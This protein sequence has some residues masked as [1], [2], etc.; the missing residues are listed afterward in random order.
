MACKALVEDIVCKTSSF[1]HVASALC[2]LIP[3]TSFGQAASSF[4]A[5]P[6]T[7]DAPFSD[8]SLAEGAWLPRLRH[9]GAILGAIAR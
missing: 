7:A 1:F 6:A 4:S 2:R 9:A 5:Q 8:A 3:I